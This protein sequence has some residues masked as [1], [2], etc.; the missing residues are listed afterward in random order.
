[1]NCEGCGR[2]MRPSG[3]SKASVPMN[4]WPEKRRM[5][6]LCSFTA[7]AASERAAAG[8]TETNCL[9]TARRRNLSSCPR[10]SGRRPAWMEE[11]R[12]LV[13]HGLEK[14]ASSSTSRPSSCPCCLLHSMCSTCWLTKLRRSVRFMRRMEP[15]SITTVSMEARRQ[16]RCP[17][18]ETPRP[19]SVWVAFSE[20][21]TEGQPS[22]TSLNENEGWFDSWNH[23]SHSAAP[24][25]A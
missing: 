13:T 20:R 4:E 12:S 15:R 23:T 5:R 16:S 22:I 18:K 19:P 21:L 11:R 8:S 9:G 3:N 7:C 25:T 6:G 14:S 17:R 24:F 1:M 10:C 2:S